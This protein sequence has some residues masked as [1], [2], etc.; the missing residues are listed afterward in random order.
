MVRKVAKKAGRKPGVTPPKVSVISVRLGD[1]EKAALDAYAKDD[2]RP[3]SM[4][5]RKILSDTL[6]G[7]G[8]LK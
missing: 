7:A 8:Y 1:A 4:M 3:I 6:R 2:Q 5:I